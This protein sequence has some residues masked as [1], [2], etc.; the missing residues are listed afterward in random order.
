MYELFERMLI[1]FSIKKMLQNYTNQ[2]HVK[3]SIYKKFAN[4]S[5]KGWKYY[6]EKKLRCTYS[7]R[8]YILTIDISIKHAIVIL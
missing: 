2:I 5:E 8:I 6:K 7:K 4:Q 1:P 3:Q